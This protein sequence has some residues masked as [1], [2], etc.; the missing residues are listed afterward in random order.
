[1]STA[2]ETRTLR[3]NYKSLKALAL[4]VDPIIQQPALQELPPTDVRRIALSELRKT[5]ATYA[6]LLHALYWNRTPLGVETALSVVD[7][8]GDSIPRMVDEVVRGGV[9]DEVFITLNS[10]FSHLTR[11]IPKLQEEKWF[12]KNVTRWFARS[13]LVEQER[14]AHALLAI[15]MISN[16][17]H[18]DGFHLGRSF[19]TVIRGRT[20]EFTR[21][22]PVQC[23]DWEHLEA[24]IAETIEVLE[25]FLVSTYVRSI[26]VTEGRYVHTSRTTGRH[27]AGIPEVEPDPEQTSEEE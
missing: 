8:E 25:E 11:A 14:K 16:S 10:L 6:A 15:A 27:T 22:R 19:A 23:A 20:F 18:N 5:L 4:M 7:C 21:N 3:Q 17:R 24:V 26:P 9:F 1:M 2:H 13:A 12:G